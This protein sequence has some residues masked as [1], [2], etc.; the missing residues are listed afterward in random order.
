MADVKFIDNT[1][2]VMNA[3]EE[4]SEAVLEEVAGELE[5][6]VKRNTRVRSGKTKNSWQATA[7]L[8]CLCAL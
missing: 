6:Q 4:R 7:Y 1:V 5:S 2:K 8:S 3:I